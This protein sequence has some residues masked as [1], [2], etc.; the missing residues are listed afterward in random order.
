MNQS[1]LDGNLTKITPAKRG[2]HDFCYF[3]VASNNGKDKDGNQYPTDFIDFQA[4]DKQ[5]RFLM[6]YCKVG[7]YVVVE[8]KLKKGV[9]EKDG[10]KTSLP[11]NLCKSIHRPLLKKNSGN[12]TDDDE[13]TEAENSADNIDISQDDLP[14]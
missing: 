14:F 10:Q 7:D 12:E 6:Q 5:A 8:G 4:W 13:P 2:E 9:Y 1:F 3:T 11:F